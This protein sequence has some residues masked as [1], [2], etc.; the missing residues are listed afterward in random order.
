MAQSVKENVLKNRNLRKI[1]RYI[2]KELGKIKNLNKGWYD[3][4]TPV[5]NKEVVET[6]RQE[7]VKMANHYWNKLERLIPYPNISPCVDGTIDITWMSE[8]F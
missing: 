8:T 5:F 7:L 3:L 6:T 1:H 4:N 2:E